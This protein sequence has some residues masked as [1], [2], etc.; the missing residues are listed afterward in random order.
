MVFV[1]QP[2]DLPRSA[3]KEF[4][5]YNFEKY[6]YYKSYVDLVQICEQETLHRAGHSSNGLVGEQFIPATR[7]TAPH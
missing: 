4:S 3:N 6:K 1:E 7:P 5:I 2:L